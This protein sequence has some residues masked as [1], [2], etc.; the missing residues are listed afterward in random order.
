MYF[1]TFPALESWDDNDAS[2][3]AAMSG[4]SPHVRIPVDVPIRHMPRYSQRFTTFDMS[5]VYV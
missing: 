5:A 1:D 3:K 2:I 4:L